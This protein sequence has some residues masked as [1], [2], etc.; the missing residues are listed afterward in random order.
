MAKPTLPKNA[1]MMWLTDKTP[2]LKLQYPGAEFRAKV[3]EE[4]N[5]LQDK[6][7]C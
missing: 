3:F 5:K 6:S 1:Y 2:E 4:W 7:V